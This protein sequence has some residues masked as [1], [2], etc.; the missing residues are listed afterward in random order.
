MVLDAAR[1]CPRL[2]RRFPLLLLLGSVL[3]LLVPSPASAHGIGGEAAERSV[4]GFVPLGIEHMLLGWDHILF[5][6]G[7][8][9]LAGEWRRAAK[10]ISVFV[11]GHSITLITATMA[12]WQV[13]ATFVDVIIVLSVVFVGGYGMVAGRPKRWD[14][15]GGIV[16]G[17]G[18]VHG[19]GLAT[20]FQA[21]GV[22]EDGMLW[23]VIAFNV[24]IEIGQLT[25][26]IGVLAIAAVASMALGRTREPALRQ[27]AY[28]ALFGVGVVAAP[29]MAYQG[30]T[31][32]DG[33]AGAA[34]VPE[35]SGCVIADRTQTLPG[36]GGGHSEKVFYEPSEDAPMEDLGHSLG[37]G[38]VIV[39]Y[40]DD[41]PGDDLDTLR[42]YT[43]NHKYGAVLAAAHPEPT[44]EVQVHTIEQT[45]TCEQFD[46]AAIDEFSSTWLRSIGAE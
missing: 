2:A 24:G 22:P 21:L 23:R 13:N 39:L 31:A 7:V 34:D 40:A 26:I 45:M 36:F 9:L 28:A 5:I 43:T 32:V 38:Y 11:V 6:G 14:I 8:V 18:L 25:A 17:F 44:S 30:F 33:D 29:L 4:L 37:D 20:R 35:D 46:V 1:P 27:T 3:L 19:L 16:F 10:L 41:L 12:G 15:F 42:S